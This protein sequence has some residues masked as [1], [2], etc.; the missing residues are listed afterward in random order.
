MDQ[1]E[2]KLI[3]VPLDKVSELALDGIISEFILRE[4]TDYGHSNKSLEEKKS[5]LKKQLLS[6]HA[7]IVYSTLTEDTSIMLS[8]NIPK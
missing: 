7:Q 1:P 6:K 4:G 5:T 8:H 2:E 3:P